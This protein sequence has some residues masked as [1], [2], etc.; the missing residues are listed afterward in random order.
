MILCFL[1]FSFFSFSQVPAGQG[2]CAALQH[3][4]EHQRRLLHR[5]ERARNGAAPVCFLHKDQHSLKLAIILHSSSSLFLTPFQRYNQRG[6]SY[7]SNY[8]YSEN[9]AG[10][11]YPINALVAIEDETAGLSFNVAIDR[12][13][14]TPV[15]E[16]IN[17]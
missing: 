10:N 12:S 6:P 17:G 3:V 7:P 13:M 2:G 11:Y 8:Q 15:N 5:L 4:T 14:G 9:V 16:L 1:P